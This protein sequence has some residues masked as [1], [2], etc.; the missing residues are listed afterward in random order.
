MVP[1]ASRPREESS[2]LGDGGPS[3][4]ISTAAQ[5][6]ERS[7]NRILNAGNQTGAQG[8]AALP[9]PPLMCTVIHTLKTVLYPLRRG[10]RGGPSA[11]PDCSYSK[12]IRIPTNIYH[13]SYL[14]ELSTGDCMQYEAIDVFTINRLNKDKKGLFDG[15][16]STSIDKCYLN[17]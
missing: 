13:I 3:P 4:G 1:G 12:Q 14:Q 6:H 15:G 11:A 16:L 2:G 10:G 5:R 8:N 7:G 17:G 9:Y